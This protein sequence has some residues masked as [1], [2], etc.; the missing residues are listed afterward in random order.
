VQF[1][2]ELQRDWLRAETASAF[3]QIVFAVEGN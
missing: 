2:C 1:A 3:A